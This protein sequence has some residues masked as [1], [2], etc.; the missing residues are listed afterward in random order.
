MRTIIIRD[1]DTSFFTQPA[2]LERVYGKLWAQGKPVALAVIPAQTGSAR[3]MHRVGAPYDPSIPPPYRGTARAYPVDDNEGLCAFLSEKAR[4]GLVELCQHGFTHQYMEWDIVHDDAQK[5]EA[6]MGHMIHT[7][8]AIFDIAFASQ[9]RTFIA[10]YDHISVAALIYLRDIGYHV[11]TA[12]HNLVHTPYA[13]M[14]TYQHRAIN[15]G[16]SLFT[17]D[18]YLFNHRDD[19]QSCLQTALSRLDDPNVETVIIANHYWT[20]FYDWAGENA[21]LLAAWDDFVDV[22]LARDDLQFTTFSRYA[23]D[24][25]VPRAS[26]D[27]EA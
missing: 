11:C 14:A 1:D 26:H 13:Q 6:L 21:A 27:S 5:L 8:R 4:S 10:P 9:P 23:H 22:L 19:P 12:A 25:A 15:D 20:F 17:C 2:Q 18:E 3:V 16:Q 24:A 7:G